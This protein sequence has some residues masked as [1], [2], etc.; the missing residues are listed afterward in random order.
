MSVNAIYAF[1]ASFVSSKAFA[2]ATAPAAPAAAQPSAIEAFLLPLG[3]MMGVFY[4]LVWRPQQK[5]MKEQ[6]AF[7]Q[8]LK[9]GDEVVTSSGI[10]GEITGVAEKVITVQIAE[11][12]KVKMLRSQILKKISDDTAKGVNA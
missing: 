8:N 1:V 3:L 4:L 12:V 9:K 11:G 7:L 5:K 10:L 6:Q 2:Q